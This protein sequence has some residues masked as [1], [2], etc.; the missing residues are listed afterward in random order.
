MVTLSGKGTTSRRGGRQR[1]QPVAEE[2][3]QQNTDDSA[4]A[5]A[6][7]GQEADGQEPDVLLDVSELEVD[8]INLEVEDL[9]LRFK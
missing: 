3:T 2:H 9:S 8:R 6:A 4:E 7:V 1:R 5:S